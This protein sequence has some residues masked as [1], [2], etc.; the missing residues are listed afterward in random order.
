MCAEHVFWSS[1][2]DE[3]FSFAA[4][5]CKDAHDFL[6]GEMYAVDPIYNS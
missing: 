6:Y 5:A 1:V 3:I 2:L 4:E